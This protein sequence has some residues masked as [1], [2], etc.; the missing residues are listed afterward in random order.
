MELWHR[1]LHATPG[2]G[3]GALRLLRNVLAEAVKLELLPT[4]PAAGV[5]LHQLQKREEHLDAAE[6]RILL[7]AIEIEENLG[8]LPTPKRIG[9]A[10]KGVRGGKGK[11]DERGRGITSHAAG[12]LRLLVYTGARLREIMHARWSWVR[13]EDREIALPDSKTG[14]R[15][16]AL[17]P[18][19]IRTLEFLAK[20]RTAGSPWI[21]E[22]QVEGCAMVNA[23]KPWL[24]VKA[25]AVELYH[26]RREKAKLPPVKTTPFDSLRLHGLRHTNASLAAGSGLS[27]LHVGAVLGHAQSR[28]TERYSHLRRNAAL[29]TVDKI[30]E[31]LE[32][33]PGAVVEALHPEAKIDTPAKEEG[34]A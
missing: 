34:S 13:W 21:I 22:G 29:D 23:S 19:A 30:A 11:K 7:D 16:I 9:E 28:T 25:R 32:G 1:G 20:I 14:A 15:R 3:N 24:R 33:P 5:K 26:A 2:T 17:S 12:L 8:W 4:N 10:K 18:P 6:V 31:L 27:L